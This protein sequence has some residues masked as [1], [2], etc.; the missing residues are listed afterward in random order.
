LTNIRKSLQDCFGVEKRLMAEILSQKPIRICFISF[1]AYPVFN[2]EIKSV[3]GGAEVDLYMIATELAKDK[4]FQ[5]S[6]VV[7]DYGQEPIEQ[8]EGITLLKSMDVKKSYLLQSPRIWRA[9]GLADSQIYMSKG[10][11]LGTFLY[12]FFCKKKKRKY[13]VRTSNSNEC[14]GTYIKKCFIRG[15]FIR[16]ALGTTAVVI[17]QNNND[18]ENLRKSLN[19]NAKVIRNGHRLVESEQRDKNI[20][21]WIGR[22]V[23]VKRPE[24]FIKLAKENPSRKFVMICQKPVGADAAFG[25]L[26]AQAETLKN[27]EFIDQVPFN[28]MGEYYSRASV[29]VN[30]SDSEGFPN[31]FIQACAAGTPVLSLKVNPDNFLDDHQCGM[32]ADDNWQ[33]FTN[34]L[35][36]LLEPQKNKIYGDNAR[37]Y[38]EANHDIT[39]IIETY[40]EIFRKAY[41]I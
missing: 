20:I 27:L 2:P 11:S 34:L 25:R 17:T 24:L 4:N 14:D 39:I 3:F 33:W 36:K 15:K 18:A 1:K 6:F 7:G 37:K 30:T 13:I 9:L 32:S 5:V 22:N 21:L 26:S 38:A 12:A 16:W 28:Q 19:L 31:T 29:F 8:R 35:N 10:Y 23:P 40:K 41:Q